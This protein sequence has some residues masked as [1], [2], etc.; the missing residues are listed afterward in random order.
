ME[1]NTII[2][3]KD[4]KLYR[5]SAA[6]SQSIVKQMW[7][8]PDIESAEI[9]G[10]VFEYHLKKPIILL[11]MDDPS[12]ILKLTEE[13]ARQNKNNVIDALSVSFKIINGE[14]LR[15]SEPEEDK[16]IL[17]FICSLGLAGFISK[18]IRKNIE[19]TS[20]FHSEVGICDA[21]DVVEQIGKI[22]TNTRVDVHAYKLKMAREEKRKRRSI[23][24]DVKPRKL[25]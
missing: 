17:N 23:S 5:G 8:T 7:F 22:S 9:Y 16:L 13:A 11:K 10:N 3:Q 14:I 4:S 21:R 19:G 1:Y 18:P 24:D 20:F 2:Y 15:N 25:F 12:N 6:N